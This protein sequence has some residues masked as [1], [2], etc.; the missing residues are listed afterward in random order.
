MEV[1]VQQDNQFKAHLFEQENLLIK[2]VDYIKEKFH[3]NQIFTDGEIKDFARENYKPGDVF[4]GDEITDY[5]K[6]YFSV[7]EVFSDDDIKDYARD[8][9]D[10]ESIFSET[11]LERW[12][13]ANGFRKGDPDDT[14]YE[15]T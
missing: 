14:E 4:S 9:Y 3:M 11:E 15:G 7:D 5:C 10:V 12:A 2:S 6:E 13:Q 8:Q 1:T